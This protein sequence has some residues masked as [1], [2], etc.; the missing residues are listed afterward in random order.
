MKLELQNAS[1]A[2]VDEDHSQLSARLTETLRPPYFQPPVHIA[3]GDID[4][5]IDAGTYTF[6]IDLPAGADAAT[7]R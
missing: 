4:A 1:V 3:V 7:G 5:A 6:V 2:V